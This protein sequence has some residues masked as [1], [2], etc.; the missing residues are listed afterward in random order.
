M[1]I[2]Q[3]QEILRGLSDGFDFSPEYLVSAVVNI[4]S[5][6]THTLHSKVFT[7]Q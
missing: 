4:G 7:T 3:Y 1:T 6:I 2:E 5:G